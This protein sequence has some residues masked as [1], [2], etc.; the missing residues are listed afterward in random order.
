MSVAFGVVFGAFVVGILA[1][2]VVAVRWAVQRDRLARARQAQAT[3][4][5]NPPGDPP[6]APGSART[7]RP[8]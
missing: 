5:P 4:T 8:A 3:P 7:G 1:L 6:G 2:A